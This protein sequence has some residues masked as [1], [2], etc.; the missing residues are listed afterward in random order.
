MSSANR[1]IRQTKMQAEKKGRVDYNDEARK[2]FKKL[3]LDPAG[4]ANTVSILSSENRLGLP[5]FYYIA[6]S[7]KTPRDNSVG[8]GKVGCRDRAAMLQPLQ[9]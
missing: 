8:F 4:K 3:N 1:L 2:L 7:R 6:I 5:N 9:T